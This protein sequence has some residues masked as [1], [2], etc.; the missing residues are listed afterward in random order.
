M[1]RT[2]Y[3]LF[4][5][6]AA[7]LRLCNAAPYCG[8]Q[9]LSSVL[10]GLT[11]EDGIL[12]AGRQG[13]CGNDACVEQ[14]GNCKRAI[15]LSL[16]TMLYMI[17]IDPTLKRTHCWE[18]F[19]RFINPISYVLCHIILANFLG[20]GTS[21]KSA[22]IKVILTRSGKPMENPTLSKWSNN[23]SFPTYSNQMTAAV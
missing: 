19:V 15:R 18:A 2:G 5:L 16:D 1:T 10:G 21:F 22:S 9:D 3:F 6:L 17:A 23:P 20:R 13:I 8:A 11:F 14:G 7:G 4:G 12:W